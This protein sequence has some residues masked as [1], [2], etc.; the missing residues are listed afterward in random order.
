MSKG[1]L[2]GRWNGILLPFRPGGWDNA[3]LLEL[4]ARERAHVFIPIPASLANVLD[5]ALTSSPVMWNFSPTAFRHPVYFR[6]PT[7]QGLSRRG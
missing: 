5:G 7:Q 3:S 2:L 6:H 4:G 1:R